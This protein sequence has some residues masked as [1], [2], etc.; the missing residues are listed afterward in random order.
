M[1][2][3]QTGRLIARKWHN[4]N[5]PVAVGV[6]A[7]RFDQHVS[8]QALEWEHSIYNK[9]FESEEL[10][11]CL[12]WQ[13]QNVGF[14]RC[15]DGCIKYFKE[16]SRMSGDMNTALGNCML[17]CMLVMAYMNSKNVPYDYINNG[18][19]V[20]LFMESANLRALDDL[21]VWFGE[22][23]FTMV[24]ED[25]VYTLEEIEFCQMHPIQLSD[26]DFTMVRSYPSSLAKDLVCLEPTAFRPWLKSIGQGGQS[27]T[28]GVPIYQAFYQCLERMG[29]DGKTGY[30][31]YLADSGFFRMIELGGRQRSE[32]TSTARI[33]FWR[34]FGVSPQHQLALEE[35]F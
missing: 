25:P 8:K 33:S 34:A 32:I 11:R 6:D 14:A 10:A 12:K 3:D 15:K 20:V 17:M 2:I 29:G 23:G 7:S 30:V 24:V 5:H 4:F 22:M 35:R 19:D 31:G 26:R 16:G 27:V 21:P 18:D 1:T 28:S 13:V 9:L